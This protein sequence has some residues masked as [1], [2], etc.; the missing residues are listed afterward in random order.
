MPWRPPA[1]KENPVVVEGVWGDEPNRPPGFFIPEFAQDVVVVAPEVHLHRLFESIFERQGLQVT[2]YSDL[3]D[4]PLIQG[5]PRILIFDGDHIT[6]RQVFEFRKGRDWRFGSVYI[7]GNRESVYPSVKRAGFSYEPKKS[8]MTDELFGALVLCCASWM[9]Y[10]L[11][12]GLRLQAL[13]PPLL[14]VCLLGS[15]V[16]FLMLAYAVLKS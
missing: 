4:I 15:I 10:G 6:D 7:M 1:S 11:S 9:L 3:Q 16:T 13:Q 2:C 8:F 14:I 5:Q 12:I